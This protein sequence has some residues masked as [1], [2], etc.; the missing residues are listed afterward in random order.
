MKEATIDI[1]ADIF[2]STDFNLLKKL[3]DQ[4]AI[5]HSPSTSLEDISKNEN[6]YPSEQSKS[7]VPQI[8]DRKSQ[9]QR[10]ADSLGGNLSRLATNVNKVNCKSETMKSKDFLRRYAQIERTSTKN[11]YNPLLEDF[12]NTSFFVARRTP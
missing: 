3:Y 1:H 5:L 12:L 10:R 7:G 6:N 8:K 11:G 2:F 9:K 4:M